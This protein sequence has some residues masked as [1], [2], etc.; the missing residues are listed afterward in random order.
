MTDP[1]MVLWEGFCKTDPRYTKSF[2]RTGGF[3]G[4]AINAEYIIRC[5]TARFGP[6]GNEKT[7]GYDVISEEI[8]DGAPFLFN[9]ETHFEK[10]HH[11]AIRFW[12]F[13]EGKVNSILRTF[14][15]TMMVYQR[16]GKIVS[17]EEASEKSVT[18]ALSKVCK[19][20]GIG[21]DIHLG[22]WDDNK[23]V[24]ERVQEV[25]MESA[26]EKAEKL[27]G[28]AADAGRAAFAAAYKAL[29]ESDR[30]E[31]RPALGAF[32]IRV[33]AA[34]RKALAAKTSETVAQAA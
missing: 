1:N 6:I 28:A 3:S 16:G 12:Y 22:L 20:L 11:V 33:A 19:R 4:T 8:V 32:E 29:P 21:A 30:I 7:W 31:L 17:D 25:A 18:D 5:L 15:N 2:T 27:L 24:S 26:K 23:Y 10:I 9:N 14:G 13:W 34:D